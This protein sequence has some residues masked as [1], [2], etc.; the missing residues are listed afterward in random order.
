MGGNSHETIC[1]YNCQTLLN[2]ERE[3]IGDVVS[4]L[5]LGVQVSRLRMVS[6]SG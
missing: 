5:D 6:E 3:E 1:T 2:T 4:D